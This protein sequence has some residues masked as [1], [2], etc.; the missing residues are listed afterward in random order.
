MKH[1]NMKR[2]LA[3]A[4]SVTMVMGMSATAFA[5]GTSVDAPIYSLNVTDVIVP[6]TYKVAFN[7][8]ELPVK[9]GDSSSSDQILSLNY[10]IVNRSSKDKVVSVALTVTDKNNKVTF[11]D[12]EEALATAEADDYAIYLEA[13]AAETAASVQVG[14]AAVGKDTAAAA[15]G[16]VAMTESTDS[17]VAL[18]AGENVIG[19]KLDKATYSPKTGSDITLG[20]SNNNDVKDSFE[21]SALG[22]KGVTAFTFK[23]AMSDKS[24]W[25]KLTQGI[26][27]AAVYTFEDVVGDEAAI[28]SSD[29]MIR[30]DIAP[31]FATGINVGSIT[32]NKGAGNTALKKIVSIKLT[33]AAGKSYDGY[34]AVAN[35]WAAAKDTGN[36]I[37]FDAKFVSAFTAKATAEGVITYLDQLDQQHTATI[38][39]ITLESAPTFTMGSNVGEIIYTKGAGSLALKKIV[40]IKLTNSQ[41]KSYD[42]YNALANT[43]A[44]ATDDGSVITFD[45]K[46][47]A[48]FTTSTTAPAVITYID[49][50]DQEQTMSIDVRTK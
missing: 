29:T 9:V 21:I 22:S 32:Y 41:G 39:V 26:T 13:V 36:E 4:L 12:S 8:Q 5:D 27:I 23:G 2:I 31:T 48:S 37:T 24:D 33:T 7:P 10:G 17:K 30:V 28:G 11:V 46:F 25:S 40:T 42:G 18:S 38:T 15:L 50:Q 45:S 43:W 20:T 16:D 14:S 47:M 3:T 19:F 1:K 6:T 35:T 34:N 44:A 49:Q